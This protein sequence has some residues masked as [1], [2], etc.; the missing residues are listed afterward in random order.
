MTNHIACAIFVVVD[1]R[2]RQITSVG[3]SSERQEEE[4]GE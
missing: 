2:Q 4:E 3:S 1:S